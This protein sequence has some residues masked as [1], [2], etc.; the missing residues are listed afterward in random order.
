MYKMIYNKIDYLNYD[1]NLYFA[2]LL[3]NLTK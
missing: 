1:G 3:N 2:L